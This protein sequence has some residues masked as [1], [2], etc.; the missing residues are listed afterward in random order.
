MMGAAVA[1]SLRR[2][3][4]VESRIDVLLF[5]ARGADWKTYNAGRRRAKNYERTEVLVKAR[6]A[7]E[8]LPEGRRG[9]LECEKNRR[10]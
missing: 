3:D 9:V 10:G 4:L 7:A 6:K 8:A 5:P 1:D 2:E